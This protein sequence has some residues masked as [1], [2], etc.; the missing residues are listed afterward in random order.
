M[1]WGWGPFGRLGNGSVEPSAVPV[2]VH[3]ELTFDALSTEDFGTCGI[4]AGRAYC[5]G[6]IRFLGIGEAPAPDTCGTSGNGGTGGDILCAT[7]PNAVAGGHGFRP[8]VALGG[9]V[10]CA[11]AT[12][13]QTYCWG[14]GY[15][16]N[17]TLGSLSE[18]MVVSGGLSFVSLTAGKLTAGQGYVCGTVASGVAYCWGENGS[19]QLGNGTTTNAL[20]PVVV[21]GDNRFSQLSAGYNHTCGVRTDGNAYCWGANHMGELGTRSATASLTPARV[22]LFAP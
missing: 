1:C 4:A 21:S 10:A 22:R 20:V 3:G 17:G 5:W 14:L 19:G 16:G 7:E 13:D 12:D 2:A 18:P 9:N 15:L 11:V 6:E 8:I